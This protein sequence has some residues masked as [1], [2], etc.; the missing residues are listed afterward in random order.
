MKNPEI[1]IHNIVETYQ[2]Y[3]WLVLI[4]M[5]LGL[6]VGFFVNDIAYQD[7]VMVEFSLPIVVREQPIEEWLPE[8]AHA[9]ISFVNAWLSNEWYRIA[10]PQYPDAKVYTLQQS[11]N[12]IFRIEVPYDKNFSQPVREAFSAVMKADISILSDQIVTSFQWHFIEP[13]DLDGAAVVGN[14]ACL[15]DAAKPG[16]VNCLPLTL[17]SAAVLQSDAY[18]LG[19][20]LW[21]GERSDVVVQEKFPSNDLIRIVAAVLCS[22]FILLVAFLIHLTLHSAKED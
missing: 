10:G 1:T 17:M 22:E 19:D 8:D 21:V 14:Q 20:F 11:G 3:W 5:V 15:T 7:I 12:F 13:A 9:L 2:R 6:V 4:A 18:N 16:S